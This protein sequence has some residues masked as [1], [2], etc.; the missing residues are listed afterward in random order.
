MKNFKNSRFSSKRN[1]FK[2]ETTKGRYRVRATKYK[3]I[4]HVSKFKHDVEEFCKFQNKHCT[5]GNFEFPKF[6]RP[7]EE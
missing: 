6:M 1:R 7:R 5:W 4:V 3:H 2:I